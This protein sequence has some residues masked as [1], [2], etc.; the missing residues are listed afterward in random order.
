[1]TL[2]EYMDGTEYSARQLFA[3]LEY[4]QELI[5]DSMPPGFSKE[6]GTKEE[7]HKDGEEWY[8]KHIPEHDFAKEKG[9]EYLAKYMGHASI[10]GSILQMA[11]MGISQFSK[12]C[13]PCDCLSGKHKKF[14]VG[15]KVRELPIGLI[16]YA[17]R[18]QYNHWDESPRE[19]TKCIFNKLADREVEYQGELLSF[20]DSSFDIECEFLEIY[21]H[22]ILGLIKWRTYED[23]K[24][25]MIDMLSEFE[26]TDND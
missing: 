17:G 4:Y 14:G 8:Q 10:C 21:S 2:A 19:A 5:R 13:A 15:R 26:E 25:D 1:M 7:F 3:S 11:H 12:C 20:T 18:N 24:K 9:D 6:G 23:Y 22:N 16:I